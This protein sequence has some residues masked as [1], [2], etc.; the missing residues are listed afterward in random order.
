MQIISNLLILVLV[1]VCLMLIGLVLIQKSKS[2]G[3]LG[4]IGGGGG[5]TESL[6]GSRAGNVLT[7]AT[8]IL[9]IIFLSDALILAVMNS[10][11]REAAVIPQGAPQPSSVPVSGG[12]PVATPAEGLQSSPVSINL[13]GNQAGAAQTIQVGI[14][15]DGGEPIKVDLSDAIGNAAQ[16]VN[17]AVGDAASSA[18]EAVDTAVDAAADAVEQAGEKA[19]E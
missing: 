9:T 12:A 6:F 15:A 8:V 18:A 1:V 7:K 5:M 4:S 11:R 17:I 3:G 14:P 2:G 10:T 19:T 16:E 13:D